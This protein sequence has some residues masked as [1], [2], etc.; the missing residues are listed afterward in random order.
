M[1]GGLAAMPRFE[2]NVSS[3][4][5]I[6]VWRAVLC[7]SAS[8]FSDATLVLCDPERNCVRRRVLVHARRREAESRKQERREHDRRRA[9]QGST[10]SKHFLNGFGSKTTGARPRDRICRLRLLA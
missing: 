4:D 7:S 8:T 10:V 1:P 2:S 9:A 5:A 6:G 3:S